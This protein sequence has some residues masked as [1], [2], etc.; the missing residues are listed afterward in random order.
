MARQQ[1]SCAASEALGE[2][3]LLDRMRAI[4]ARAPRRTAAASETPCRDC[5]GRCGSNAP[6]TRCITSRSSAREHPRHVPRLVGADAVLAGDRAAG[7]DAVGQDL[8]RR[9]PRPA[10]PGPGSAR[11]SRSADA[12]CRRRR[13]TRCRCAAPIA[14]SSARMRPSTSGSLRARH[15]AVLHVVVRRHAAHRRERRLAPLPDARALLVGRAPPRSSSRRRGGRSPRPSANSSRDFGG[16]AVE[17][18]DQ[19]GVGRRKVRMH[20]RFGRLIASASIIS[21]AA[22]MMPARDDRR[23]GGAA[24]RRSCRTPPAAS[25]RS[26]AGAGSAR[27]TLVT[28]ASVP[29]DA[30]E[31]RRAGR[32]RARRRARCR[33]A[34]ARRRAA[35]PRRRARGAR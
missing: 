16:R 1:S 2:P 7:L 26:R 4:R 12:G 32:D 33:C 14:L 27:V 29:S 23:H 21:T 9:P 18:D 6:R 15:D 31:Q 24:P 17:L 13:G 20:R 5:T 34:R 10:R 35:P 19:H 11:R 30:D 25:A 22:G 3:G 8:A 28:T